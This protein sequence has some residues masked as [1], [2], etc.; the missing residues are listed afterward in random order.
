MQYIVEAKKYIKVV[1]YKE[2]YDDKE[3]GIYKGGAL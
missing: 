3:N 1:C 2:F